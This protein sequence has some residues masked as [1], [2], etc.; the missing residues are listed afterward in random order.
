VHGQISTRILKDHLYVPWEL[1]YGPD[2][3]IWFTQK[4]GYICRLA[5][6]TGHLDTVHFESV[7]DQGE[8][9]MMGMALDPLF[10]TQ[11]YV[12]LA[13]VIGPASFV[14]IKIVKYTYSNFTLQ[15]PQ[16]ILD[17]IKVG[18]NHNGC[19]LLIVSD[20]LFITTGDA[21]V[22]IGGP[23]IY[24]QDLQ[25]LNGKI[26]RINL[27]G[28]IPSDNPLAG[29]AI[30]SWGHRNSQG[31][32]Y[33]N[34]ILYS[35]EHGANTDDEIN[36]IQKG[37]NYGWPFVEGFCNTASEITFC[38]DSNVVEPLKAWTPTLAVCGID[39]Y[40]HSLFPFLQNSLLMTT[41][42]DRSLYQ[43]MLNSSHDSIINVVPNIQVKNFGRL[44][45]LC[46]SPEGKIYISTSEWDGNGNWPTDGD[47]IIELYD[48]MAVAT[49]RN[50]LQ[51]KTLTIFP[52]PSRD[53]IT[54][55]LPFDKNLGH[56]KY[57]VT[58]A[59]GKFILKGNFNINNTT[60][61]IKLLPKGI[62]LVNIVD[63]EGNSF[64]SKFSKE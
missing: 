48:S 42:K 41:L 6:S 39:Y 34:G 22:P 29:N 25:S 59:E 51:N 10:S 56:L 32:I 13:Y 37:R 11:P 9:G 23:Y 53:Y 38:N 18:P 49:I 26:L 54:L 45:D 19:R 40:N 7:I 31:L 17:S 20:K 24:P 55:K 35:S 21:N 12:Y 36:I 64:A 62:Y 16:V 4:N 58:N 5:P 50:A 43:M 47:K 3:N 33:A 44:R 15:N 30:W 63:Q 60:I 1:I 61:S 8:S 27:D 2:S 52:N 14:H 28:T 57:T 46:I